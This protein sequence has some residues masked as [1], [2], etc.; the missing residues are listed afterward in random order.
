MPSL[1]VPSLQGAEFAGAEFARCRRDWY[2]FKVY[3]SLIMHYTELA[4]QHKVSILPCNLSKVCSKH[5]SFVKFNSSFSTYL[6]WTRH[7]FDV[8]HRRR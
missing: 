8:L 6:S 2:P 4:M 5:C 3:A 1:W 7:K